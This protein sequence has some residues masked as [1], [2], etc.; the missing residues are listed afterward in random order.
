MVTRSPQLA[1]GFAR[2]R[3][4]RRVALIAYVV[5]GDPDLATTERLVT[6]LSEAGVDCIE[7][8]IPSGDPIAD[9]PTIA[10]A[11]R[12]ALV[13]GTT[14]REV[15]ALVTRAT[16][17]G[18][19]PIIYFT[20]ANPVDRFGVDRFA[21]A[22]AASGAAGALVPDVPLE[23]TT[24]LGAALQERGLALPLLVAPTTP[25][26]RARQ[27]CEASSG[28]VYAVS[29][30]GV[31]GAKRGPDMAATAE[32]VA[33]LRAATA[34]PIAVGFGI[35]TAQD[36]RAV[37]AFA[38]GAIVGSAL[39]DAMGGAAGDTAARRAAAFARSLVD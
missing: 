26:D 24:V 13:A 16:R 15:F 35:A 39:I 4:Q 38:D 14:M 28:F 19:A 18:C 31:T 17:D 20:Y 27:I 23:E 12:R 10:R 34:L 22:A 2:A 8:G 33:T 30:V 3:S 37:A 25:P 11:A 5:A 6:A 9:G 32:R 21:D 36:V 1:E 7:L 29:R